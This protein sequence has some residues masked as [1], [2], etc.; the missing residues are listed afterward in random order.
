MG[1]F[2][3]PVFGKHSEKLCMRQKEN[4]AVKVHALAA[5]LLGMGWMECSFQL[6]ASA[7][8][9]VPLWLESLLT[10]AAMSADR[11]TV[12]RGPS[13]MGLG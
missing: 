5:P 2:V 1:R 4:G 9:S 6:W 3:R 7:G 10:R 13:F 12:V 8:F 11:Q